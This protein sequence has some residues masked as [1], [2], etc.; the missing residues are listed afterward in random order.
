MIEWV[1]GTEKGVLQSS[2]SCTGLPHPT[3]PNVLSCYLEPGTE[4]S[5]VQYGVCVQ[6]QTAGAHAGKLYTK[7]HI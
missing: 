1:V 7:L 5:P 3:A 6:L 2:P 4:T